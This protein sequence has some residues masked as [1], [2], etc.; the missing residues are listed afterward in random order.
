MRACRV[1]HVSVFTDLP[2]KATQWQDE[3][4]EEKQKSVNLYLQNNFF[5]FV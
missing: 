3:R 4:A 1:I 2:E 5:E